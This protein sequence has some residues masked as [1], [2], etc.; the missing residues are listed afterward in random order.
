MFQSDGPYGAFHAAARS[1]NN[2]PIYIADEPNA[3]DPSV[4][5]P[6]F[7]G[8]VAGSEHRVLRPLYPALPSVDSV[9]AD[10]R[11]VRKSLK[12]CNVTTVDG[13][14]PNGTC[15]VAGLFNC[16]TFSLC[17]RI[18]PEELIESVGWRAD[19]ERQHGECLGLRGKV[20]AEKVYAAY[21]FHRRTVR[22]IVL[23]DP[24]LPVFLRPATF[25][26]VTFAPIARLGNVE[27]ACL[28]L[29][30]KYNGSVALL[31]VDVL[32]GVEGSAESIGYRVILWARGRTAFFVGGM[33]SPLAN[34]H[35][36]IDGEEVP[37]HL[38]SFEAGLLLV[39]ARMDGNEMVKSVA[40]DVTLK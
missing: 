14:T 3:H 31:E 21:V 29:A 26:I 40:I 39:D 18:K 23:G 36:C 6:L 25:E 28:G 32:P 33:E 27:I 17:D 24:G 4:L 15:Y 1:L 10:A 34:L 5:R 16:T 20:A 7:V 22:R 30:D 11:D 19:L 37:P 9:F 38:F 12:I 13:N 35:I 2:G 8:G